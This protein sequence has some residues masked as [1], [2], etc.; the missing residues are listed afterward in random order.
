MWV[1]DGV[2]VVQ[3]LSVA[4]YAPNA[5]EWSQCGVQSN[6]T[7][8]NPWTQSCNVE[9]Y[10]GLEVPC[11]GTHGPNP[12]GCACTTVD[13]FRYLTAARLQPGGCQYG[14]TGALRLCALRRALP[15]FTAGDLWVSTVVKGF[16]YC[17]VD[18]TAPVYVYYIGLNAT[19]FFQEFQWGIQLPADWLQFPFACNCS[20]NA[21]KPRKSLLG[22][23]SRFVNA[24]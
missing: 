20:P 22:L 19:W 24:V 6:S 11:N 18:N 13:V 10:K 9:C 21:P 2:Q 1:G 7:T 3:D 16:S 17:I 12:A 5:W 4:P 23:L 8:Y 15:H 14:Y